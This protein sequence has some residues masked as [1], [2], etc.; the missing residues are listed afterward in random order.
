[1]NVE[2]K[3]RLVLIAL[4]SAG[5][6]VSLGLDQPPVITAI[7]FSLFVTACLYRFLGGVES[8]RLAVASFKAT[9]GAALGTPSEGGHMPMKR[10]EDVSNLRA[11]TISA[12]EGF[13]HLEDPHR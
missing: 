10:P 4:S 11:T 2:K 9:G 7:S 3:I 5:G 6:A 1:M 12:R 13:A 8:S